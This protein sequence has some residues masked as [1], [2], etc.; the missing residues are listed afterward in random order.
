MNVHH[1]WFNF[2]TR[3]AAVASRL[4]HFVDFLNDGEGFFSAWE[5]SGRVV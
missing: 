4:W 5:H 2:K 3:A 1:V